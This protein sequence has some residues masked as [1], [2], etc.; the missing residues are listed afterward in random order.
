MHKMPNDLTDEE[1][2]SVLSDVEYFLALHKA[3]LAREEQERNQA[4]V[5][6]VEAELS[7]ARELGFEADALVQNLKRWF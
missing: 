6:L 7:H 3:T 5:D 1:L 4:E 2:D